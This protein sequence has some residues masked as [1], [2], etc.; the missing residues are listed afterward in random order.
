MLIV[1]ILLL[2]I[3]GINIVYT[4][5]SNLIYAGMAKETAHQ[6]GTP[7]SSL[8]GWIDLL[9]DNKERNN[10]E[11]I[12]SLENE[13]EHI[14][15]I[16]NKFNKIGSK[17]KLKK[18]NITDIATEVIN[19]FNSRKPKTKKIKIIFNNNKDYY[20][21]GD[22]LLI[23]WAFE[24]LIKNSIESIDDDKGIIEI[25]ISSINNIIK[26]TFYDNGKEILNKNKIFRP[27]Y[28]SKKRGWALG[29]SL[30]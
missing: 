3:I 11:I 21:D 28:S 26:L 29:L 18:I 15:N 1:L 9:K 16:S 22:H 27:G 24:N 2:V 14:K 8:L 12:N 13:I 4:S 23:Y 10:S 6:L 30:S 5:E 17:P 20:I 7:I 19:Y 25:R